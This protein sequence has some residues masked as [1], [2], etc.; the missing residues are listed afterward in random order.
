MTPYEAGPEMDKAVALAM[1][2]TW[3]V[4]PS[5]SYYAAAADGAMG[6]RWFDGERDTR[7]DNNFNP[8]TS[9]AMALEV[10]KHFVGKG[11]DVCL[12]TSNIPGRWR[13]RMGFKGVPEGGHTI[14][15]AVCKEAL[16]L[17][18]SGEPATL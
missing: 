13:C 18:A 2:W 16:R 7:R 12:E 11:Y 8:S 17:I 1:G 15:L 10:L 4:L 9:D 6:S 5:P 3:K 14:A